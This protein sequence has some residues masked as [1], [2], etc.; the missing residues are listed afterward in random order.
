MEDKSKNGEVLVGQFII[1]IIGYIVLSI[2]LIRPLVMQEN[3]YR[4]MEGEVIASRRTILESGGIGHI[5]FF[6]NGGNVI[7]SP[8]PSQRAILQEQEIVG[9]ETTIWLGRGMTGGRVGGR[10][11]SLLKKMIVDGEVIIPFRISRVNIFFILL[12]N[13]LLVIAIRSFLRYKKEMKDTKGF[14]ERT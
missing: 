8:T 11:V 6:K 4:K 9:K 3:A 7:F 2:I 1:F 10:G 14:N 5:I 13:F 12:M